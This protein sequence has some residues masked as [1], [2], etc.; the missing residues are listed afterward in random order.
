[1]IRHIVATAAALLMSVTASY[2]VTTTQQI[3]GSYTLTYTPGTGTG[4]GGATG[5]P[6]FSS[7]PRDG[8]KNP[9]KN[10]YG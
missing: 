3:T 9:T 6:A 8:G 7:V 1:M 2:A 5:A 10:L 4:S